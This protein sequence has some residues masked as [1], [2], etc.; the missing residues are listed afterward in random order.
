MP[1]AAEAAS[2]SATSTHSFA[3]AGLWI[4]SKDFFVTVEPTVEDPGT[5]CPATHMY[6]SST[7]P[8]GLSCLPLASNKSYQPVTQADDASKP[9][10]PMSCSGRLT[11]PMKSLLPTLS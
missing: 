1:E 5:G 4:G 8:R 9:P 7:A 11:R 3:R 6:L 2:P 10:L